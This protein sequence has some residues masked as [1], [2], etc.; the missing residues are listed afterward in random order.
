MAGRPGEE[1]GTPGTMVWRVGT[2]AARCR[3][4]DRRY[5]CA[6]ASQAQTS[7]RLVAPAGYTRIAERRDTLGALE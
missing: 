6:A 1:R 3:R 7:T 5:A 4:A 2:R